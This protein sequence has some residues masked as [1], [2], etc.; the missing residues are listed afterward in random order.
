[1]MMPSAVEMIA[2]RI[3]TPRNAATIGGRFC[4]NS[5]GITASGFCS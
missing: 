3:A 4:T 5:V 1:M 2:L